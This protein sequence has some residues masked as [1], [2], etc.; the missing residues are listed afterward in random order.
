MC[1]YVLAELLSSKN[2]DDDAGSY[3]G[4]GKKKKKTKNGTDFVEVA[5][6]TMGYF[7]M[8]DTLYCPCK[9]S[10]IL[11]TYFCHSQKKKKKNE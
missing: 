6:A 7:R 1:H 2:G 11:L 5:Q 10:D 8:I 4:I 9:Y 3:K